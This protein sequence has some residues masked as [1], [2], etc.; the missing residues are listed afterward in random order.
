MYRT[1]THDVRLQA[2]VSDFDRLHG[3]DMTPSNPLDPQER[4]FY[5]RADPVATAAFES[6]PQRSIDVNLVPELNSAR[7]ALSMQGLSR[8][9][10]AVL[11]LSSAIQPRAG[12]FPALF[13]RAPE[14]THY[15]RPYVNSAER[16]AAFMATKAVRASMPRFDTRLRP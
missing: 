11:P 9:S 10:V 8:S 4:Y 3:R 12:L 5:Q 14:R 1:P 6:M 13:K 15:H 16:H 2:E 7:M